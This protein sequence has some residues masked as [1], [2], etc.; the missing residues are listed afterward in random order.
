LAQK[1]EECSK[2]LATTD[3]KKVTTSFLISMIIAT[4]V[5]ASLLTFCLSYCIL[6]PKGKAAYGEDCQDNTVNKSVPRVSEPAV[7]NKEDSLDLADDGDVG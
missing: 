1:A 5:I 2:I 6:A 4:G 3:A 7:D